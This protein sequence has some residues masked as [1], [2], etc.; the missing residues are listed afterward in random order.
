M[1]RDYLDEEVVVVWLYLQHSLLLSMFPSINRIVFSVLFYSCP[2]DDAVSI[3]VPD[4]SVVFPVLF[5]VLFIF[6]VDAGG[7]TRG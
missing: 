3:N 2:R 4:W 6:S 1:I 7:Y 5:L